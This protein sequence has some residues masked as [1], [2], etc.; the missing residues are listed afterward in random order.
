MYQAVI[1]LECHVQ[2][3]TKTKLFCPCPIDG[4]L[5]PNS[6]I[7]PICL[8][9]P[10]TL[11]TLNAEA[12]HLGI[13]AAL[14]ISCQLHNV[15][16]FERKQYFYPD[17][18]KGYQISQHHQPLATHGKLTFHTDGELR[19][20]E[21][22]RIHLEEDAG[23]STYTPT[24][25]RVDFNRAGTPLAEI[26]TEPGLR[27]SEEAVLCLRMLHRVLV[28]AGITQGDME[29]GHLRCDANVS[30]HRPGEPWGT[31]TEVKNLN[32]FRNVARAIQFEIDRQTQVLSAGGTVIQETRTW[33]GNRTETMRSKGHAS[34]YRYLPEPDLTPLIV[35]SGDRDRAAN[36]L[37]ALPLDD[38]L[39]RQDN[40]RRETLITAHKLDEYVASVLMKMRRFLNGVLN[41]W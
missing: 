17:L 33:N 2:L 32:S 34:D 22:N 20:I 21:I 12:I 5:L 35:T 9:H 36:A 37:V 13:R 6:R 27:S 26:V 3:K 38:W 40:T 1:G 24:E 39:I 8:G 29:R 7:C 23:K 19:T 30:I 28:A 16:T 4:E 31:R 14:A 41:R 11:P 10:G 15:S 25:T 18:S